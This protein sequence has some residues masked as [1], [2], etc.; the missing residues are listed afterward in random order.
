VASSR[1]V[2]SSLKKVP[3]RAGKKGPNYTT[4]QRATTKAGKAAKG[5]TA[6]YLKP[7][8]MKVARD[9][10]KVLGPGPIRFLH[11]RARAYQAA[12]KDEQVR[13]A[14]AG[15]VELAAGKAPDMSH[16][17]AGVCKLMEMPLAR[18]SRSTILR[19]RPPVTRSC[20]PD[21]IRYDCWVSRRYLILSYLSV[22]LSG[23]PTLH[24]IHQIFTDHDSRATVPRARRSRIPISR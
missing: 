21:K 6:A 9:A 24:D 23:P 12:A 13:A 16:L 3:G 14:F 11:D 15:G 4:V 19:H 1:D 10:K 20:P 22:L 5:I 7:V 8:L 17:D 2:S 18:T